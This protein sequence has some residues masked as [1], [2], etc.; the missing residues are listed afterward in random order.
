MALD[1]ANALVHAMLEEELEPDRRARLVALQLAL[2]FPHALEVKPEH[3]EGLRAREQELAVTRAQRWLAAAAAVATSWCVGLLLLM[4][5]FIWE[6]QTA[7]IVVAFM[8]GGAHGCVGLVSCAARPSRAWLSLLA[9]AWVSGPVFVVLAGLVH[10]YEGGVA[11]FFCAVP[12]VL[13]CF[14]A[15]H[16]RRTMQ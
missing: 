4:N 7:L 15:A 5:T 13:V 9:W 16:V 12:S 2:G 14:A 11:A 8:F 3:L 10:D 6:P 1:E